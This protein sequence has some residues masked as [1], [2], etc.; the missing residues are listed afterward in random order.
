M[1]AGG[2][3]GL[4]ALFRKIYHVSVINLNFSGKGGGGPDPSFLDP[5]MK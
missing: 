4:E 1:F 5:R 3:G 2:G